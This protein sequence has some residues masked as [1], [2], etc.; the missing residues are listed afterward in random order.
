MATAYQLM[1]K[2]AQGFMTAYQT[3]LS[4]HDRQSL[5]ATK[6]FFLW[7][8]RAMG[9]H[10]YFKNWKYDGDLMFPL[11]CEES[12]H[13]FF[14]GYNIPGEHSLVQITPQEAL[15]LFEKWTKTTKK[16]PTGGNQ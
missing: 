11:R 14:L 16:A 4:V 3:D 13:K 8:L 5:K 15:E 7:C 10:I 9:T 12:E 2:Q 6:G 1:C